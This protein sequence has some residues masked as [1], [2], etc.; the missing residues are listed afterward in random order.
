MA[1]S[2][3]LSIFFYSLICPLCSAVVTLSL[4][5]TLTVFLFFSTQ[6]VER[7]VLGFGREEKNEK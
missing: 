3:S 4:T 6:A 2:F 1:F 5:L 7:K